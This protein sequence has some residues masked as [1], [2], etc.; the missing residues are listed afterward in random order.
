LL[1]TVSPAEGALNFELQADIVA[2]KFAVA[3]L[4]R[5]MR[6]CPWWWCRSCG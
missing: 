5:S 6:S 4:P 3:H 1:I 2:I